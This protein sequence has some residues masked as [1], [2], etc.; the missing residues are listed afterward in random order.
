MI[1]VY[2]GFLKC[3]DILLN[4][5]YIMIKF[6]VLINFFVIVREYLK[7][8]YKKIIFNDIIW[9]KRIVFSLRFVNLEK[10]KCKVNVL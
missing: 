5:L 6:D 2:L 1:C 3:L 8:R 4:L 7:F 9:K 10:K